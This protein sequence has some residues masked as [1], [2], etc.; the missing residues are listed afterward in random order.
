M[1]ININP[2]HPVN[3]SLPDSRQLDLPG[4]KSLSHRAALFAALAEGESCIENFQVSGV[5][6]PL[7]AALSQM[8]VQWQLEEHSLTIQGRG[9]AGLQPPAEPIHCG[10]SATTLRLL[11]GAL[12]AA[13]IP[14]VLDGSPGLCRRPMERIVHP[15][16][17]MGVPIH[18]APGECAPLTLAARPMQQNLR[19]IQYTLPVASAQVK[20]CLLLAALAA[21]GPSTLFEPGPSRDHTEN[22]LGSMGVKVT[23]RRLQNDAG[24]I[25]ATQLTPPA[26]PLKPLRFR[27]PG[28]FSAAA[29][30]IVATLITP[31]SQLTLD[32]VGL[33]PT[34]TGLL[35]A[36]DSMGADLQVQ[37]ETREGGEPAGRIDVRH[38]QLLA[39]E[40]SGPLVVRM[41]D[42]FPVFAVAAAFAKGTTVVRQAEELRLKESN[43]IAMICQ[44][45]TR[46]GVNIR[47]TPDGFTVSGAECPRGGQVEAHGDHRLAMSL[48]VAGLACQGPVSVHGAEMTAESFPNFAAILQALGADLQLED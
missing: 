5:T 9:M 31:G 38:S 22:M 17:R 21:D 10:N 13:G 7:L 36:L 47:E 16:Q 11:A 29:F 15:L 28:D 44:E 4:D 6:R 33:N 3:G 26:A 2:G 35:D 32:G 41:I 45:L 8:G 23:S 48:A 12:A 46:L 39:T 1:K 43:R 18:A 40:I 34:R 19:N 24:T 42:E 25:Y 30:L 20:S 14:A 27:L 37:V